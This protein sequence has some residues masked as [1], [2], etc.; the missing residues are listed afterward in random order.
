ML[1]YLGGHV[2]GIVNYNRRGEVLV[3]V[4]NIFTHPKKIRICPI[5]IV[6]INDGQQVKPTAANTH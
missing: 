6:V 4:V 3:E 1:S 5:I 2:V